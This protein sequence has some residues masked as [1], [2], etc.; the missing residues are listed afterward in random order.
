[1]TL[2]HMSTAALVDIMMQSKV[3][4]GIEKPTWLKKMGPY[5]ITIF[6]FLYVRKDLKMIFE[7]EFEF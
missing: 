2:P 5:L 6:P 4:F 1:M 7:F 3:H